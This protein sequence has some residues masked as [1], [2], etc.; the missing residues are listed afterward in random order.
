MIQKRQLFESISIVVDELNIHDFFVPQ[1]SSLTESIK[2]CKNYFENYL[3]NYLK[4]L[5]C[6]DDFDFQIIEVNDFDFKM[7]ILILKPLNFG[8]CTHLYLRYQLDH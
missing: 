6:S 2:H 4:L 7:V 5:H 8:D 3:E 1:I